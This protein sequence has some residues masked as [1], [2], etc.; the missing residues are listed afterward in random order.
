MRMNYCGSTAPT[1]KIS[2]RGVD[3]TLDSRALVKVDHSNK[4][5]SLT[6]RSLK[7]EDAGT[8]TIQ[9]SSRGQQCD[10][11]TFNVTVQEQ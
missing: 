1:V 9:L 2:R 10:S 7:P 8:Y 3:V 6:I 5:I 4:A 11:A